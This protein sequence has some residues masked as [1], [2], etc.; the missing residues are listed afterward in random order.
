MAEESR[1]SGRSDSNRSGHDE[2]EPTSPA[3]DPEANVGASADPGGS[4]GLAH[5]TTVLANEGQVTIPANVRRRLGLVPGDRLAFT[6][7]A[8]GTTV[9]RAKRRSIRDLAGSVEP[10]TD[11][12]ASIDELSFH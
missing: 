7:L 2:G 1:T 6:V 8:D 10:G 12:R 11:R 5:G 4:S 3:S 9:M